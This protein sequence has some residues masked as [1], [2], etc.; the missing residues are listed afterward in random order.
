VIVRG[1]IERR[2]GPVIVVDSKGMIELAG[3]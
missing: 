3:D 1:W 2:R